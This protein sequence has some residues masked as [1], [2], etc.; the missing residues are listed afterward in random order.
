VACFRT[1]ISFGAIIG[2]V[3]VVLAYYYAFTSD[4]R[5]L[6]WMFAVSVFASFL[7]DIDSDSG[8]PYHIIFGTF[9]VLVA[10][11]VLF[12]TINTG[13]KNVYELVGQP[14]VALLFVWF[15]VGAFFKKFTHHR[16]MVHSVPA[17]LIAVLVAYISVNSFAT[18][19][20]TSF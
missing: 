13:T 1:H 5:L 7:P 16:G 6:A 4:W 17:L 10:G 15:V 9:T 3:G 11:I 20:Y 14:L 2:V 19:E 12:Y 8:L 18:G